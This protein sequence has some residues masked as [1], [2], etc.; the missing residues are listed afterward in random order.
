MKFSNMMTFVFDGNAAFG[1]AL[2]WLAERRFTRGIRFVFGAKDAP[3]VVTYIRPQV[4]ITVINSE[5]LW[6]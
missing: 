2:S 5:D 3:L 4:G 6:G 1:R